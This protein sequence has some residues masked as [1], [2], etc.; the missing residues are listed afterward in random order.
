MKSWLSKIF[1]EFI[2]TL[3]MALGSVVIIA[4]YIYASDGLMGLPASPWTGLLGV[5]VA[6]VVLLF[7]YFTVMK[8]KHRNRNSKDA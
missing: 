7:P 4:A 8:I 5:G 6:F 2:D 1:F 3:Y